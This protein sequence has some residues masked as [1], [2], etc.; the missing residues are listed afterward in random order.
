MML[1]FS[2]SGPPPELMIGVF[3]P[4]QP[5]QEV[6][7]TLSSPRPQYLS[8]LATFGDARVS[9]TPTILISLKGPPNSSYGLGIQ[10]IPKPPP[11]DSFPYTA[12]NTVKNGGTVSLHPS[13]L[14][15]NSLSSTTDPGGSDRTSTTSLNAGGTTSSGLGLT[16]STSSSP[17]SSGPP[18]TT[19]SPTPTLT[20]RSPGDLHHGGPWGDPNDPNHDH[21]PGQ[22][23]KGGGGGHRRDHEDRGDPSPQPPR[24]LRRHLGHRRRPPGRPDMNRMNGEFGIL[25]RHSSFQELCVNVLPM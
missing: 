11:D 14:P 13:N 16:S 10:R 18:Y 25:S 6:F 21:H 3:P 22:G 5:A 4:E 12:S 7:S 20:S 19:M 9:I 2:E 8:Y 24:P 1:N 15:K 17:N 23:P